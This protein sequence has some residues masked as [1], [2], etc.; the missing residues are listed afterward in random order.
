APVLPS[1]QRLAED[2]PEPFLAAVAQAHEYLASGDVFQANLSRAWRAD[3][4]QAIEPAAL[5]AALR[6]ANPAPFAALW[7]QPGWA[8]ASSSPERLVSVRNGHA[9]TRPIAGTR[10][11]CTGDDDAARIRE[12]RA[13]PKERAEHI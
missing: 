6:Q 7:Q 5:Y 1:L 2:D 11:R 10:P 13:H 4:A 3:F 12:L 8:V 9:Q